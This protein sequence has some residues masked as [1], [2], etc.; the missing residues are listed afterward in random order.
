MTNHLSLTLQFITYSEIENLSSTERIKKLLKS[1]LQN[2]IVLLQ[3]KLKVEE[4]ARLIEDTMVLV[5][6]IKGFKGIEL[7]VISPKT[8][9]MPITARMKRQIAKMLIGDQDAV[10]IIGPASI[11]R[12]I[13][14]D[15]SKI[16][17]F[18]NK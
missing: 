6:N 1:I 7:E 5:G 8:E 4:E 15:P 9:G 18:L 3:G 12:E 13:K 2:K 10:T 17:L 14:K 11:V 16:Q